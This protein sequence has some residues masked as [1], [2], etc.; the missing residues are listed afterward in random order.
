MSV[1]LERR[2]PSRP[3]PA[4]RGGSGRSRRCGPSPPRS[5]RTACRCTIGASTVTLRLHAIGD[6]VGDAVEQ[7]LVVVVGDAAGGLGHRR[8]QQE[9]AIDVSDRRPSRRRRGLAGAALTTSSGSPAAR[10][11]GRG[12]RTSRPVVRCGDDGE[13]DGASCSWLACA[14]Y[15]SR[16][17]GAHAARRAIRSAHAS[18]RRSVRPARG[19]GTHRVA[20]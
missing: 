7:Q 20:P 10:A 11:S 9:A 12:P 14:T 2:G 19:T 5:R 3:I 6:A 18:P 17:A 13:G 1:V 8:R 4:A 15:C 16:R